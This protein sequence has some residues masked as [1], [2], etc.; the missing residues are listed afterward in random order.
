MPEPLPRQPWHQPGE[1]NASLYTPDWTKGLREIDRM[2]KRR[3]EQYAALFAHLD[4]GWRIVRPLQLV[5]E[6]MMIPGEREHDVVAF[7][8]REVTDLYRWVALGAL[9]FI[10]GFKILPEMGDRAPFGNEPPTADLLPESASAARNARLLAMMEGSLYFPD[11]F[12]G[13]VGPAA[14]ALTAWEQG[15]EKVAR[16]IITYVDRNLD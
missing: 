5:A 13:I 8:D 15:M 7:V 10:P 11:A 3:R 14:E 16:P 6:S 2:R 9:L 12:R 4:A 1:P